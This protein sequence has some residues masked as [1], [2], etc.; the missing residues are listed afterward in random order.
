MVDQ[1]TPNLGLTK[2]DVGASDDTWGEKLNGN[3]DILDTAVAAAAVP[4]SWTNVTG[5]PA[6]FPPDAHVHDYSTLTGVP[7]TFPPSA[8]NHAQGDITNLVADLA[9][10]AALAS[11]V[12]T[13]DPKA[14]TPAPAD[15]DTSIAT[16]AFVAAAIAAA[17]ASIPS[18]PIPVGTT[19]L[20]LQAAAPTGW[21]KY[22]G[23]N[24]MAL[25]VVNGSG[26][27]T[28]GVS[29]FSSVFGKTTTDGFTLTNSY[30]GVASV[31]I[32]TSSGNSP[33]GAS[34]ATNPWGKTGAYVGN[35]TYVTAANNVEG[36]R[37]SGQAHSH[38]IE[39]RV[40]HVDAIPC[41]KN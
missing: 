12:F 41:N 16:T 2:P 37:V 20:F 6:T 27:G 7:A 17:L 32:T 34:A 15:N 35:D 24:D 21:T 11:P 23:W 33:I 10:K 30:M 18:A 9:A 3:F 26:G 13:G 8:H 31:G 39:M 4:T 36:V 40:T 14:P 38:T 1:V 29:G 19:M 22:T 5:K 25:R 28:G